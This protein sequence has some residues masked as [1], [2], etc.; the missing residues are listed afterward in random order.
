M[1]IKTFLLSVFLLMVS[2]CGTITLEKSSSEIVS[3]RG[4]KYRCE[5]VRGEKINCE[6]IIEEDLENEKISAIYW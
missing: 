6:K 5:Y 1:K 4:D 2:A 3:L